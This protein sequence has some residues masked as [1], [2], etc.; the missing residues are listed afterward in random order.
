MVS[1]ELLKA[2]IDKVKETDLEL[3]YK[4]IKAVVTPMELWERY[5]GDRPVSQS[6]NDGA[7]LLSI[8]GMFDSGPNDS[9]ENASAIVADFI[10]KKHQDKGQ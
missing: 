7:F 4:I 8:A 10:L 5:P 3:V 6:Q 1:R 2:E 9:S